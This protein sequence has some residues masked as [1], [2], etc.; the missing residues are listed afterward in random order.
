MTERSGQE[1]DSAGTDPLRS[2]LLQQ[3]TLLGQQS[4]RLNTTAQEVESLHAQVSELTGRLEALRL[5]T[6]ARSA[7][8]PLVADHRHEP[9]ANNPPVYDGDPNACQAFL[10]QCALVFALQPRRYSTEESKV[11][12][13]ITLLSGRAR[14]WGVAVWN[15]RAPCCT[16]FEDFRAEMTKLFDRSA[17]GD[18][19]AALL[20]RLQQ[21]GTTITDYAI[22]F[23]TLGAACD[24]NASALRARFLEGLDHTIADEMAVTDLPRDLDALIDLA[25]R[26]ESRLLRRR[27]LRSLSSRVMLPNRESSSSEFAVYESDTEPMQLGRLRLTPLQKQQRISQGLCLYCGRSGH[28][29]AKCPLKGRAHQ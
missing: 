1:M 12:Y 10:S 28:F 24:W 13:V 5:E 22:R 27:H 11:A 14:E 23:K 25:L 9:H 2:A 29:A 18:E 15:A 21:E 26:V 3:G 6:A 16:A 20:S 4:Q 19:A 7:T 8:S 17:R